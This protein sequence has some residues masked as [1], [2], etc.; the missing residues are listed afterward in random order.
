M[1]EAVKGYEVTN[2][3][4]MI[5]AGLSPNACNNHGESILHMVCRRGNMPLFQIML[6]A[7]VDLQVVDDYGRS[8]MHDCCWASSPSFEIARILLKKDP[9]LLFLRDVRGALPLSYVTKSNW[10]GWNKF[11]EKTIDEIFPE[12]SR[13]K[14]L[15]PELCLRDP[16]TRPV[17]N[18][19]HCI[20]SS[21]ANMVA[22]GTM[23]PYEVMLAVTGTE[24]DATVV[25][26]S[27]H[28]K[29][30]ADS[31]SDDSID[32]R[33][34]DKRLEAI[35]EDNA[36]DDGDDDGCNEQAGT[37]IG[38]SEYETEFTDVEGRTDTEGE[39]AD[40]DDQDDSSSFDDIDVDDIVNYVESLK[41]NP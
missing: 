20:P 22:T 11:I 12:S 7:G 28:S 8:P 29:S 38:E 1:I 30:D 6:D 27:D 5:N 16:N 21:L 35:T 23:H 19:K 2:F 26:N 4:R 3:R 41:T 39:H 33:E 34:D 40:V 13:N 9:A 36:T 24:D 18:P 32:Q 25:S 10:G 31:D 15:I 17:A 37:D 14:D